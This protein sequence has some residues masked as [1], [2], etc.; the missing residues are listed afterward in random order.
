MKQS[1]ESKI[2]NIP[3]FTP[4]SYNYSM[5]ESQELKNNRIAFYQDHVKQ[6]K[7]EIEKLQNRSKQWVFIRLITFLFIPL[8][9]YFL[10]PYGWITALLAVTEL[11]AFL[12]FV[13]KSTENK[14][15]LQYVKRLLWINES[16]LKALNHD[17]ASF[18]NGKKYSDPKH[19][20]SYDI[21]LFG[22][23]G[24]FQFINR[25]VTSE[26]E[27]LLANKLL[28]GDI[29][30]E[31]N[32]DSVEE[33]KTN[34]KWSQQFRA[35]GM[36]EE[37]TEIKGLTLF[38]WS[39]KNINSPNWIKILRPIMIVIAV[40]LTVAY[41]LD[42]ING[43]LFVIGAAIVLAPISNLLKKTNQTH[44]EL[45]GIS[46]RL[47]SIEHQLQSLDQ[48]HFTSE[49]L[50]YFKKQLFSKEMKGYQAVKELNKITERFEYR[51]NV[52]VAL[53]LNFYLAWDFSLLIQLSKW[54]KNYAE[55]L[56]NWEAIIYE[57]EALISASTFRFNNEESTSY[58]QLNNADQTKMSLLNL[59]HPLIAPDK[60]VNNN[61]I[62]EENQQFA[63]ITGPNMAGKS[64]FLRSVAVNLILAKAG[65]PVMAKEFIFPNLS[66]Y[67]SM[68]TS[69]DLTDESSYF[70]AELIRLRF[71][72]D[73]IERGEKVFIILDEI[74]KGTNSKDK[75]EGSAKFLSK[76]IQ[77][78]TRGIIATHDLKLTEL[79]D[80]N[81]ALKN[82]YF[83][84]TIAGDEISF[85]YTVRPGVAQN[86]NASFLLR[87]MGLSD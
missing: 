61:Y 63:I 72:V 50:A 4:Q 51:N 32:H 54:K 70:H 74:L 71:I 65:F 76:L 38:D 59:G 56:P 28:N 11:V 66:L 62:M 40:M 20:F 79:A 43:I 77:L 81:E 19:A 52:L 35:R 14:E 23:S 39:K 30:F 31:K 8:T 84:T 42:Y 87:K 34:M 7:S 25:T 48:V 22:E 17:Y 46:N 57:L 10:Y 27:Q 9:I 29:G 44:K 55:L 67:S 75:E 3:L 18:P 60:R 15:Q 37:K 5:E 64:T 69:D 12:Y 58:A 53:L 33:L 13:R 1:P 24:F 73:A 78:N 68:R 80:D 82:L 26:G 2:Y 49:K 83:D 21:D 85:D 86:M 41:N 16:E 45:N 6:H 47:K 36:T